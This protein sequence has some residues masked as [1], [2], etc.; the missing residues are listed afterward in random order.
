METGSVGP[1]E[2]KMS[3]SDA[4]DVP[5]DARGARVSDDLPTAVSVGGYQGLFAL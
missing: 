2:G 4:P 3:Q 5:S 1:V